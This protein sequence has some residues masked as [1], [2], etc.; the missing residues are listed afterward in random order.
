MLEPELFEL[1]EHTADAAWSVTEAGEI[2]S[3][4]AAAAALFG[5]AGDD[6]L[7]RNVEEVLGARDA[8]GTP[9]LAAGEDSAVRQLRDGRSS[10]P[11]F[12]MLV[13][14]RSGKSCWVNVSTIVFDNRRTGH[15]LFV[16]LA[17]DIGQYKHH[18]V[19]F[20]EAT[21]V[22]RELLRLA[23]DAAQ[24]APVVDLSVQER[25]VLR[26]LA[27]GKNSLAVARELRISPQTLRN[28]LH[29]INRKLRTHSRLEAVTHALRRGLLSEPP[30]TD[31][32]QDSSAADR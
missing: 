29:H 30:V 16:R 19:L 24:L 13:T 5:Y 15:R 23:D 22:A 3:W 2:L 18:E 25:R 6:V 31:E 28:H 4:N 14:T 20:H 17:R 10:V 27:D 8:L 32:P 11:A 12:D 9:V 7:H 26:L 21:E 1:L